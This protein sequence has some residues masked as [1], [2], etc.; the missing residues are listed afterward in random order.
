MLIGL[1]AVVGGLLPEVG[2]LSFAPTLLAVA[3][4]LP[5]ILARDSGPMPFEFAER[6]HARSP[7]QAWL[8]RGLVRPRPGGSLLAWLLV[9]LRS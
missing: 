6:D 4:G 1:A 7:L 9:L 8:L 2:L 3:A 5:P